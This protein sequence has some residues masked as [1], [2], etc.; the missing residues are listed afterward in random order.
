M[1]YLFYNDCS[2]NDNKQFS[3]FLVPPGKPV[4]KDGLGQKSEGIIRSYNEGD[5]LYLLCES[6]GGE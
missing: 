2:D 6:Q 1:L 5:T 3:F 4:I